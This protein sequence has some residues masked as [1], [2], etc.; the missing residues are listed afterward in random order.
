[1]NS[2]F[3]YQIYLHSQ[4]CTKKFLNSPT[5]RKRSDTE[6][7]NR[8]TRMKDREG[9]EERGKWGGREEKANEVV[10]GQANCSEG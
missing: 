6:W 5:P 1:M 7:K 9:V 2:K 8:Q 3:F 10:E 4:I